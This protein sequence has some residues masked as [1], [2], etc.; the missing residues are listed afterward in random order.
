MLGNYSGAEGCYGTMTIMV[1]R[2]FVFLILWSSLLG[3][4]AVTVYRKTM[5]DGSTQFSD[6]PF[7]GSEEIEIDTSPANSS[8]KVITEQWLRRQQHQER[9]QPAPQTPRMLYQSIKITAPQPDQILRSNGG[10]LD[11]TVT[12]FPPLAEG[13]EIVFYIDG[14][15]VAKAS[16]PSKQLSGIANGKH[17]LSVAIV[18]AGKEV[19]KSQSVEFHLLRNAIK[20]KPSA[21]K[22]SGNSRQTSSIVGRLGEDTISISTSVSVSQGV[23]IERGLK[24]FKPGEVQK[25]VPTKVIRTTD[26]PPIRPEKYYGS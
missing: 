3:A 11:A 6:V 9:L 18:S 12:V 4:E 14:K 21:K 10:I 19:I 23:V 2:V 25:Y 22:A 16:S 20:P 17:Q 8:Q 7:S 15:V 13:D 24:K 1:V 5:P 26:S